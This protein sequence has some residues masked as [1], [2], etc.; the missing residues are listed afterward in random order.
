V[1]ELG[2]PALAPLTVASRNR[3]E[4]KEDQRHF[5]NPEAADFF[6][7][8]RPLCGWHFLLK[9]LAMAPWAQGTIPD[10]LMAA[11]LPSASGKSLCISN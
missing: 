11:L 5:Q 1:H 4:S 6:N 3:L 7:D 10:L 2:L 9:K 8:P